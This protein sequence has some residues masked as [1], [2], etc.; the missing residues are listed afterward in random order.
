MYI[1]L[2]TNKGFL[3]GGW[4]KIENVKYIL[5]LIALLFTLHSNA[6]PFA[7]F[8]PH[9][10]DTLVSVTQVSSIQLTYISWKYHPTGSLNEED[11][12][13][14][15][16]RIRKTELIS[17]SAS[18]QAIISKYIDTINKVV[19]VDPGNTFMVI[20]IN[21]TNG[22]TET[23]CLSYYYSF[24]KSDGTLFRNIFLAR[25]ILKRAPG[26]EASILEY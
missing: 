14:Y 3:T 17:D 13:N 12:R 24:E 10:D 18:I 9:N 6:N 25:E 22:G 15:D 8:E 16:S 26:S 1:Y 20:D 19:L 11:I 2:T 4:I 7:F 21:F 5:S 23:L